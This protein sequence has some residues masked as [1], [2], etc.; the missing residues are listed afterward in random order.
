MSLLRNAAHN[1]LQ[2]TVDHI[3]KH[4]NESVQTSLFTVITE[5]MAI[6]RTPTD[7]S[8]TVTTIEIALDIL[9]GASKTATELIMAATT[10]DNEE[11]I[12]L[13]AAD[14]KEVIL[15]VNA[16]SKAAKELAANAITSNTLSSN[17]TPDDNTSDKERQVKRR[18]VEFNTEEARKTETV[19]EAEDK[20]AAADVVEEN[21]DN[22]NASDS[23][24]NSDSANNSDNTSDSTY[25]G[26]VELKSPTAFSHRLIE[27]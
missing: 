3:V 17:T 26:E 7:S 11:K 24:S 23:A 27:L 20:V 19:A 18:C 4:A 12:G 15:K 13:I 5:A 10:P 2:N 16:I 14:L 21:S 22:V 9:K 1:F 6:I 8:N 25:S